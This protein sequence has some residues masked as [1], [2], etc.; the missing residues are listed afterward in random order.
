MELPKQI[1]VLQTA[2]PDIL[3][4]LRQQ[5]SDE[6]LPI[7]DLTP[8]EKKERAA[9]KAEERLREWNTSRWLIKHVF[10]NPGVELK[11]NAD[12]KPIPIDGTH[13]QLSH[14][15]HWVGLGQGR[16]NFG[17][18]LQIHDPRC[19]KLFPKFGTDR[20]LG[21]IANTPDPFALLWCAKESVFK[22]YGGQLP[23]LDIRLTSVE[24]HLIFDVQRLNNR[25]VFR[26]DMQMI[27]ETYLC[28]ARPEL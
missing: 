6:A 21:L 1:T 15:R 20:E 28:I 10:N 16:D 17:F 26:V 25:T 13:V 11:K 14:S 19:Q 7:P 23:F 8:E 4:H 12:G 2:W 24:K 3:L 18:D 27:E 5:R 9:I 22:Y